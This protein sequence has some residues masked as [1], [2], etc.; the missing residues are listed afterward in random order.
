M[1]A[2]LEQSEPGREVGGRRRKVMGD[3]EGF[4]LSDMGSQCRVFH[5]DVAQFCM[6][7]KDYFDFSVVNGQCYRQTQAA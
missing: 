5:K 2:W 7:L 6:V 1:P 4:T 3:L